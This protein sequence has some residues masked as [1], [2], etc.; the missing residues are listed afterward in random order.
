MSNRL[1]ILKHQ[2]Y[3]SPPTR[4]MSAVIWNTTERPLLDLAH[5]FVATEHDK[6]KSK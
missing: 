3:I 2:S 1:L 4:N 5:I 6:A